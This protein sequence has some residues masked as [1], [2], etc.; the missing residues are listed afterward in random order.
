MITGIE[1]VAI[2]SHRPHELAAWYVETLGFTV[3]SRSETSE[4]LRTPNGICMEVIQA[5]GNPSNSPNLRDQ[6]LRHIA[7]TVDD[8]P[9]TYALFKS[10]GVHFLSEPFEAGGNGV[11]FFNDPEGNF[12]HLIHRPVPLT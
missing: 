2:A 5:E 4:M 7:L 12:L 8:L 3:S 9:A 11:V 6:G 1:H 10:K